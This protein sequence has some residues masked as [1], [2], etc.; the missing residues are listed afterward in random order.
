MSVGSAEAPRLLLV[1]DDR[2]LTELVSEY[3]RREGFDVSVAN[4]GT[5]VVERICEEVPDIVIL[6]LM[7]PGEDG[8]S[9]CRRARGGYSGPILM[10]TARGDEVDQV[11]GL[12]VGADDYVP[13]PASP[14][15]LLARVRALL[16][17]QAP[18]D[19]PE[20]VAVGALVIDPGSRE[21]RVGADVLELTTSEYDLLYFLVKHAGRPVSRE[22]LVRELRGI[23]YDG[24]DRSIDVRVSQLRRKLRAVEGA[25]E[26]VTVR[27]VGYQ[28]V[29]R[30]T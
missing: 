25:P 11:V 28:M 26:I 23:S 10:L 20:R 24:L 13:K 9:I 12:E 5:G 7:L 17:R 14:R 2:Q 30:T 27:S 1:D 21:A 8:L 29:A 22:M 6:D 18:S 4:E 15:L 16:R 3:F 19:A